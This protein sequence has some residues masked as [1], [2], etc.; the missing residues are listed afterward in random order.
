M[1]NRLIHEQSPYLLQHAHN[2]VDWFPW[3][4]EPFELAAKENKPI[5]VSIG[6]AACHWCH[7]MEKESFENEVVAAYMNRHFINIKVDRE[8]HPEVDHLY[9]EAV[10]G[11]TGSGGWPLNVFVTPDRIPFY[12]GTYFPPEPAYGRAS[13]MQL[14][15]QIHNVWTTK[16][17]EVTA[18]AEQMVQY[19]KQTA[20]PGVQ[21]SDGAWDLE[22]CR[23]MAG[24]LLKQADK[25]YGGFGRAPKF[26]SAMSV[27]FLLENF[28]FTKNEAALEHALHSLDAMLAGGIYDQV[29]GGLCRY[30]T[31]ATWLVPHFEK[32]LYDNALLVLALC[33]AYQ[34]TRNDSYRRAVEEIIS[35]TERELMGPSGIFYSA[36]DAD[37]EGVEGKY[38]TWTWKE[39]QEIIP[40]EIV[41]AYFGV[42]ESGNWEHTNILHIAESPEMLAQKYR[43]SPEEVESRIE[44]ARGKLF[45]ERSKRERPVTDDKSLLSWNALMNLALIHSGHTLSRNDYLDK[46]IRHM[47]ALIKN[48]FAEGRP[49]HV[50]KNGVAKIDANLDDYAFLIQAL[51]QCYAAAGEEDMLHRA[52]GL[53]EEVFELFSEEDSRF[54]YFSSGRQRDI[55]VRKAEF[56]DNAL[57]SSNAVMAQNL[58]ITGI[59]MD[60]SGWVSHAFEMMGA[61]RGLCS[62]YPASFSW[63]AVQLQRWAAGTKIAVCTGPEALANSQGLSKHFLPH[64]FRMALKKE[65]TEIPFLKEKFVSLESLIFVCTQ[66]SCLP[67]VSSISESLDLI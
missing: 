10:Q 17:S 9:M 40:D 51:L 43:V 64:C 25:Q 65:Y 62:R 56:Y 61:M 67:P 52:T 47:E 57:P 38:Y 37:S 60:R 7:V 20:L 42:K 58:F 11:I 29:G 4:D 22:Q 15:E 18:Q 19:L 27:G 2:P 31:D 53:C 32:M 5:L 13:W 35:F 66:D 3:S 33:D 48:F 36:L 21:S 23:E 34:L 8:E 49:K 28:Y 24:T 45:F 30:S 50:W 63:W 59:L 14:L 26:P 12:G 41:T 16:S 1:A 46:G 55:P 44:A 39:W 54:F 6:Y